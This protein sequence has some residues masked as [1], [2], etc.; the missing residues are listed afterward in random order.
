MIE[1]Q[2]EDRYVPPTREPMEQRTTTAN[3]PR[4]PSGGLYDGV[5]TFDRA[6]NRQ[7]NRGFEIGVRDTTIN[8]SFSTFA[9]NLRIAPPA[10]LT[11]DL[12]V[13]SGVT[14]N[15]NNVKAPQYLYDPNTVLG[16]AGD[17]FSRFYAGTPAEQPQS[18]VVVGDVG[19]TS[20]GQSGNSG[21]FLVLIV[22]AIGGY[23]IYRRFKNA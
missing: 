8:P 14:A 9:E 2:P 19:L 1:N 13:T 15:G 3:A 16:L 23:F 7:I 17:L 6:N 12:T 11:P 18:P 5:S 10:P 20:S 21:L 4:M 22:L